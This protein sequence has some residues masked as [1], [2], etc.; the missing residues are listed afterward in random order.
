MSMT[1]ILELLKARAGYIAFIV[2]V[3]VGATVLFTMQQ[4]KTY[5]ASTSMVLTFAESGPFDQMG[6]PTQLAASYIAT[7]VDII[8]NRNTALKVVDD[9]ELMQDQATAEFFI[10]SQTGK[11]PDLEGPVTRNDLAKLLLDN[12]RVRP[13]RDSRVIAVD[14][15]SASPKLAARVADAFAQ[16][17]IEVTLELSMGPARRNA[18]WFDS[19]LQILQQRLEDQQQAL[20]LYQQ[21][22]GIVAVDE[23]LDTETSRLEDL[24]SKLTAAQSQTFDVRSRQL[25]EQHPEFLR[26]IN[27]EASL[28]RSLQRQKNKVLE[29][30]KQRDQLDRMAREVENSQRMYDAAVQRYYQTSLESQFNQTNIAVLTNAVVPD[31]PSSPKAL[32][33]VALSLFLGLVFGIGLTVLAELVSRRVRVP[34]DI[35]DEFGI[36]VLAS[37]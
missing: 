6:V 29:I 10:G 23:R 18:D 14:F 20:T 31:E 11:K 16:A 21:E 25:G 17:Y 15:F 28:E 35:K 24:S 37:I 12:L 26:A 32:L 22:Q 4:V 3:T 30:K 36:P 7:Q 34:K 13:S 1:L 33:N 5:A 9:L 27:R 19:Q 8:R 2:F